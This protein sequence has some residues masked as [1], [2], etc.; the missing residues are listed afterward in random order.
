MSKIMIL[1]SLNHKKE[2]R[3]LERDQVHPMQ[4]LNGNQIFNVDCFQ[5]FGEL[6]I[7]SIA[8]RED[9]PEDI[10]ISPAPGNSLWKYDI[11][12]NI[13]DKLDVDNLKDIHEM[14]FEADKLWISNTGYD[15]IIVFCVEKQE[16]EKRVKI[17]EVIKDNNS[18]IYIGNTD[19]FHCNQIFFDYNGKPWC[20]VHHVY[21]K[22]LFYLVKS[23]IK[24][25]GDGGVIDIQKGQVINLNLKAPHSV[26]KV[27][28][29]YWVF[30]SCNAFINVYDL[31]WN[32]VNKMQ[33]SG[34]GR[35]ACCNDVYFYAGISATRKRYL[36]VIPKSNQSP[37]M[38][39]IFDVNSRRLL[40]QVLISNIEQINN[41]YKID[42]YIF[43]RLTRIRNISY[44]TQ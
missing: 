19:R 35:G 41:L 39:R 6:G 4:I 32:L 27:N 38:I 15:E 13:L 42:D 18:G 33:T 5:C 37:N 43:N 3:F 20:L 36:S 17:S 29:H 23:G 10:Y 30:D 8:W 16:V 2:D 21:G 1:G 11:A 7:S 34:F 24:K 12:R 9:R 26:R 25:Q 40:E 28:D 22:Q 44:K 31:R 14:H